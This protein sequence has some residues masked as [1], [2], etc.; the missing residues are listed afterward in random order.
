MPMWK[1]RPVG[2]E[3]VIHLVR[4][5]VFEADDSTRHFVGWAIEGMSGRVS[6]A[7]QEFDAARGEGRTQSGRVYRLEGPPGEDGD[8]SYTWNRW[9]EL[10]SVTSVRDVSDEYRQAPEES[11][12]S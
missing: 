6:S 3:P 7:I 1:P 11:T 10:N 2:M 8:A 5:R 12:R 4:W 9:C